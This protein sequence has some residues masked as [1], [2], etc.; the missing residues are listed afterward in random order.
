MLGTL[1]LP[2][3]AETKSL[4][5]SFVEGLREGETPQLKGFLKKFKTEGLA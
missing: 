1:V 2:P 4:A 5:L 3:F